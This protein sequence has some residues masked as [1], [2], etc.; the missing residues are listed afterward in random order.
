MAGN[1]HGGG[2]SAGGSR[3]AGG[4]GGAFSGNRA[5]RTGT[6]WS[7]TK[8]HFN[9]GGQLQGYSTNGGAYKTPDGKSV[10]GGKNGGNNGL[11]KLPRAPLQFTVTPKAL[12][13]TNV[14]GW[15]SRPLNLR[16]WD[17]YWTTST[18]NPGDYQRY[19]DSLMPAPV[20]A[21]GKTDFLG[22][23]SGFGVLGG[24]S[25]LMPSAYKR[26]KGFY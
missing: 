9:S 11:G 6:K 2:D 3:G 20:P 4:S 7:G 17:D 5:L 13:V 10:G 21:G 22:F 25:D 19:R 12:P 8:A 26:N 1:G 18:Y 15:P 16:R 24:K 23:G 14:P